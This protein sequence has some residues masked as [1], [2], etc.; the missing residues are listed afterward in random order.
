MLPIEGLR[1]ALSAERLSAYALPEDTDEIDCVARYLWNLARCSALQ[2]ALHTLEITV[3]NRLF[4]ISRKIIDETKLS[5]DKVPCW[6]DARPSLLAEP[7]R[8]A[9]E[10][11]KAT[12]LGRRSPLTEGRLVSVLGFGFWVSLCKRS[13]EQGRTGGPRLWPELATRGFPHPPNARRTRS[14]I[15]HALNPLRELRNRVSHHEAVW[16]RKLDRSHREIL[17]TIAWI[18]PELAATLEK[19][20]PLPAVLDRGVAGFRAQA[21]AIVK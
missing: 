4:D 7:E 9:V 11:A 20:S 2:P 3:R 12:I 14:Q 5:H 19:H 10:K 21:E 17:E 13:Y 16:D 18:N 15:F 6:L 8:D 1:S